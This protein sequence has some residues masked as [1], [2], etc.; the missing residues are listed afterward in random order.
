MKLFQLFMQV[1]SILCLI[2]FCV[3]YFTEDDP[4]KLIY[5]GV[6]TLVYINITQLV[7]E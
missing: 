6:L 7:E 2:M 1:L 4:N 3:T 5:Y